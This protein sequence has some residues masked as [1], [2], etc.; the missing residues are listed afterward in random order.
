MKK[1]PISKTRD[2][3]KFFFFWLLKAIRWT[4]LK[5]SLAGRGNLRKRKMT[6]NEKTRNE[7]KRCAFTVAETSLWVCLR[8]GIA[9]RF[10]SF[11][12]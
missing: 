8:D 4:S 9:T 10:L 11:K 6:F 3:R 12:L 2:M 1:L 7:I 5:A